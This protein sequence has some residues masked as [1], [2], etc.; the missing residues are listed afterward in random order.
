MDL[1]LAPEPGTFII[2][3]G[4]TA[5]ILRWNDRQVLKLFFDWVPSD[6]VEREIHAACLVSGMD[7]ST[8][9]MLGELS[10]EGRRGLIYE[11]VA[12]ES[13]IQLLARKP[14]LCIPYAR[15][16]AE[17]HA[18]IHRHPGTGLL[19]LKEWLEKTIRGLNIQPH[20]MVENALDRMTD[21]PDGET[22]CH[23]DF[24]PEQVLVT[25]KGQVILDWMTALAGPAAA[26]VAHTVVLLRFGSLRDVNWFMK[27]LANLL[28]MIFLRTYLHRYLEINPALAVEDIRAWL[29]IAAMAR[30]Q[31]GI[32]DEKHKLLSFLKRNFQKKS[33]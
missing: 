4:G 17:L 19:P 3:R 21:L 6:L 28:R 31:D 7:L 13:L 8:P 12:G 30:L 5:E 27:T 2:A 24:H 9:K 18:A 1:S 23:F 22:L 14:W 20:E 15:K 16:F 33:H 11:R 26:D 25:S 29:P 32:P 10:V